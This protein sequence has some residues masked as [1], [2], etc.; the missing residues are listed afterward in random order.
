MPAL[1][2]NILKQSLDKE[3]LTHYPYFVETGTFKGKT[4]FSMERHFKELHTIE[5]HPMWYKKARKRYKGNK[6]HFH[7]GDSGI[8]IKEVVEKLD[9]NAIFF[10]DSHWSKG[11]TATGPKHVPLKE[12]LECIMTY[13]KYKA[14]IIIDD[15]RLF[16][17]MMGEGVKINW[18]D[19]RK[20]I[21]Y[22]LVKPRLHKE[23]HLPSSYAHNDRLIM[24]LNQQHT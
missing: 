7:L 3:V 9:N 22:Q 24:H 20:E 13:F 18:A 5:L 1:E 23:Y 16:G 10:L 19:I 2:Y 4:I 6:I 17:K 14:I 8:K 12:E 15:F 21:I 11:N